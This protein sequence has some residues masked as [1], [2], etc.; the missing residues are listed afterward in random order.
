MSVCLFYSV[1]EWLLQGN[2]D[3]AVSQS[4]FTDVRVV[5]CDIIKLRV[6]HLSQQPINAVQDSQ[7]RLDSLSYFIHSF[8]LSFFSVDNVQNVERSEHPCVWW[9]RK[10]TYWWGDKFMLLQDRDKLEV[11]KTLFFNLF[12]VW[13]KVVEFREVAKLKSQTLNSK[14]YGKV[15]ANLQK[16]D[17]DWRKHIVTKDGSSV[18]LCQIRD[19]QL[20]N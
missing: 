4:A 19:T 7:S 17:N 18:D 11:M 13:S 2:G 15:F 6:Q 14:I 16:M 5:H 1:T 10:K 3:A 9:C 8:F 12:W 20:K